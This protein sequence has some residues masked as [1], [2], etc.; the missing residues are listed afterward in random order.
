MLDG[1]RLR[2]WVRTV[3]A[4]PNDADADAVKPVLDAERILSSL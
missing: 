4:T 2:E 3:N 1:R